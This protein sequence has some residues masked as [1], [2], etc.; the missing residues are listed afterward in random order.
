VG[1]GGEAQEDAVLAADEFF[2]LGEIVV[3]AGLLV[4]AEP[5]AIGL[6]RGEV[7][8]VVDA[9]GGGGGAFMG[10][11]ITDQIGAATGDDLPPLA[12][13]GRIQRVATVLS[14]IG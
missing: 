3:G 7:G 4:F 2:A 12:R 5:G 11:E 10:G 13:I 8:D 6:V 9:V 14:H 1:G